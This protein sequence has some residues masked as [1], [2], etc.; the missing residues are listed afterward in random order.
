MSG[1]DIKQYIA[2]IEGKKEE[3]M[4]MLHAGVDSVALP[5]TKLTTN[6]SSEAFQPHPSNVGKK[7]MIAG[8]VSVLA[9]LVLGNPLNWALV[10]IGIVSIVCGAY[11]S[12]DG[13]INKDEV[14][15]VEMQIDCREL[16]SRVNRKLSK[17]SSDISD[18]WDVYISSLKN[19]LKNA[20]LQ[21]DVDVDEKDRLM[22]AATNTAILDFSM[23]SVVVKLNQAVAIGDIE[24]FKFIISD[25][26]NSFKDAIAAVCK[27]QID[28]WSVM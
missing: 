27:E 16:S 23:S 13:G 2:R 18:N 26:E 9:G 24:S 11:Q 20:I 8:G 6:Q 21:L 10:P 3:L 17:I 19:D 28:F 4:L 5:D 15:I 1:I 25:F 14:K 12:S 7:I 22:N